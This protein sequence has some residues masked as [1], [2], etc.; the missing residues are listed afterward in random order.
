[1][2]SINGFTS[3]RELQIAC[4]DAITSLPRGPEFCTSLEELIIQ[5]CS[6][7]MSFPESDLRGLRYLSSL[8]IAECGKLKG[9]PEGLQCLTRLEKLFIDGFWEE[10]NS[11]PNFDGYPTTS[12]TSTARVVR[13]A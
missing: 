11:F 8:I 3:L 12:P 4:C 1:M 13:M 6:N 9:L 2:E 7:L 5:R 10:L